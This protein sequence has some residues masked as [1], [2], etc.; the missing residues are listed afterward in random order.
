MGRIRLNLKSADETF[1]W[2][3]FLANQLP[4]NAILALSGDLGAG[5]TTFVQG[6]A[7]GLGIEESIQSPTFVLLNL[8]ENLAHFDLYRLPQ[9]TGSADFINL[10]FHEYFEAGLICAIEW[11]E[12][13]EEI[14]PKKTVRIHFEHAKQERIATIL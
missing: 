14:L 10:G 2:G 6:L 4:K 1:A 7:S 3:A 5:K 11:P 9:E 13:I 8:Y 12:R